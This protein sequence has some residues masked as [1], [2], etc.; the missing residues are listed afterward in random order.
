MIVGSDQIFERVTLQLSPAT[1]IGCPAGFACPYE[2][3]NIWKCWSPP[4][5]P[6]TCIPIGDFRY[7]VEVHEVNKENLSQGIRVRYRGGLG[8]S[9]VE[10]VLT[11]DENLDEAVMAVDPIGTIEY[12]IP[13]IIVYAQTSQVCSGHILLWR[14]PATVAAVIVT[15]VN[16]AAVLYLVVGVVITRCR[17]GELRFPNHEFWDRVLDAVNARLACWKRRPPPNEASQS[18][19]TFYTP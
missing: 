13:R 9:E 8:G 11:C 6:A 1:R 16:A 10:L 4:S 17:E 2:D 3:A 5:A 7:G 18:C 14:D 15:V 19:E 12:P